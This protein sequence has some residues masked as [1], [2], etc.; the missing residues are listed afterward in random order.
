[1]DWKMIALYSYVVATV[2]EK[3][4]RDNPGKHRAPAKPKNRA[5]GKRRGGK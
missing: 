5:K 2:R 4:G 3:Q 1:M